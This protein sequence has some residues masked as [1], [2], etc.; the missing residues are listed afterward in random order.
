MR[1]LTATAPIREARGEPSPEPEAGTPS[2]ST[3]TPS[4]R[5]FSTRRVG[6]RELLP[7]TTTEK[8]RWRSWFCVLTSRFVPFSNGPLMFSPHRGS[9]NAPPEQMRM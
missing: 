3:L 2:R 8:S 6:Y 4:N 9:G 7:R 5:R 1:H